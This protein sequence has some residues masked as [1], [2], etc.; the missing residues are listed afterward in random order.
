M[1]TQLFIYF[2]V[3]VGFVTT[4]YFIR[5]VKKPNVELTDKITYRNLYISE[6]SNSYVHGLNKYPS[7]KEAEKNQQCPAGYRWHSSIP[8]RRWV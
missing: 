5:V 2:I 8:S 4:V 7:K 3:M 6:S 1:F